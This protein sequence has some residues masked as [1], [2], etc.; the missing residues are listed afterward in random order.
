MKVAVIIPDR[1]DRP[2]LLANC[3]RMMQAQTLQPEILIIN[4]PPFSDQPD[5]TY[6]YR[7]GYDLLR[8]R[9]FDVIAL[10]ENDDWYHPEYLEYMVGQWEKNG[11]PD[12][13]G[14]NYT[15]Y[16]HLKLRSYFKLEHKNRASAMNTLIKPDLEFPWCPDTEIY[17][18]LHLWV[19][20]KG[21]R[22]ILKGLT[23]CPDRILSIGMKHGEG[24]CGGHAHTDRLNRYNNP[25]DG[26][27]KSVLDPESFKFY[28]QYFEQAQTL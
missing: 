16:Y 19:T 1:G 26:L 17:T 28:S 18:D 25:D 11:K 14:T 20:L 27:L 2:R 13:F 3:I 7:V 22:N 6:R 23:I 15:I 12:L 4:E 5:I 24:K 21:K 9:G 10:I 8:G